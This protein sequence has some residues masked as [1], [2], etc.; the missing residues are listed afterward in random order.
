MSGASEPVSDEEAAASGAT[1]GQPA[2]PCYH[3]ACDDGSDL[4]VD[5][6]RVLTAALADV[7][8]QVANDPSLVAP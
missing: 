5:L 3:Q 8:V 7:A 1:A 4:D 2:D 6:A